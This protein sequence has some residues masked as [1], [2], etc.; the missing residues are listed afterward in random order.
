VL[1]RVAADYGISAKRIEGLTGVWVGEEKLAAIGVRI[2]R[3][4]T[5]H[6]FALNHATNLSHFDL[7]VPCGIHDV[8]MTSVAQEL[9]RTDTAAIW[10]EIREAVVEEL[11]RVFELVP[12]E[13]SE[14]LT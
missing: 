11:G 14:A 4:I 7:I 1:I 3:W 12:E 10:T 8:V 2:S 9:G 13:P 6:G 5:S